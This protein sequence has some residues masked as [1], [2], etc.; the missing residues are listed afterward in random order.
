MDAEQGQQVRSSTLIKFDVGVVY[1]K[2]DVGVV[3]LEFDVGVVDL[4]F[5]VG[6]VHLYLVD[7]SQKGNM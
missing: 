1:L 5:D 7:H 4:K 3:H 6:I 2:F